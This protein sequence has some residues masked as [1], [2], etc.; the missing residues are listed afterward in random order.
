MTDLNQRLSD[1][2][3][4]VEMI[5]TSHRYIGNMP[6]TEEIRRLTKLCREFLEPVR[7]QFGALWITSGFRC[8]KL[9]LTI[10]GSTTSA[11]QYGCAADFVPLQGQPTINVVDWI[12]DESGLEFDQVI[13]EYSSTSNWIHLGMLRPVGNQTPRKEALTMRDGKYRPFDRGV[14]IDG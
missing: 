12:V 11:H 9:N 14:V 4:L 2:F 5:R 7:S 6:N 3:T 13:D 10:G 8:E 1:H